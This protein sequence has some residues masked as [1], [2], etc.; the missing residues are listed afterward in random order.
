MYAHSLAQ[1]DKRVIPSKLNATAVAAVGGFNAFMC[2]F[3]AI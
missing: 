3:I 2:T 1:K